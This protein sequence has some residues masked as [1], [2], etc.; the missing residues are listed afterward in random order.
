[1]AESSRTS[2]LT[3]NPQPTSKLG[4]RGTPRR[5][6]RRSNAN[7]PLTTTFGR[8][9]ENKLKP[10]RSQFQLYDHQE[11]CDVTFL[12]DDGRVDVQNQVRV[13]STHSMTIHQIDSSEN[14]IQNYYLNQ[15]DTNFAFYLLG[16]DL[17]Q[18][19]SMT[20]AP[21]YYQ[22]LKSVHPNAVTASYVNY[23]GYQQTPYSQS[24]TETIQAIYGGVNEVISNDEPDEPEGND[25]I[26]SKR[27]RRRRQRKSNKNSIPSEINEENKPT[28]NKAKRRRRRKTKRSLNSG[29][30]QRDDTSTSCLRPTALESTSISEEFQAKSSFFSTNE[31]DRS[32]S[33]TITSDSIE[34]NQ[35]NMLSTNRIIFP[36][37]QNNK[38]VQ[39]DQSE[40]NEFSI[41]NDHSSS[42]AHRIITENQSSLNQSS[43]SSI[44]LV[45]NQ[46]AP[47]LIIINE[48]LLEND[49][50]ITDPIVS[51]VR[52]VCY[53]FIFLLHF[54]ERKKKN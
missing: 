52:T 2:N 26:K 47:P 38:R 5:K 15:L 22:T 18:T 19:Q 34:E 32:I 16:I 30:E 20:R 43:L 8:V 25:S 11:L 28:E 24:S 33:T 9:L 44:D 12:Y 3:S 50:L 40:T 45:R 29:E 39:N 31:A 51:Q 36:N 53:E 10:F 48:N 49:H 46:T 13:H 17:N 27:R 35:S 23:L 41:K 21:S 4:G 37:D 7:L 6:A 1:M 42:G 14:G 54:F